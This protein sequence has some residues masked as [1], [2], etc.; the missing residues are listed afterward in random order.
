MQKKLHVYWSEWPPWQGINVNTIRY[1][2][3]VY[4]Q[5]WTWDITSVY[6]ALQYNRPATVYYVCNSNQTIIQEK[7]L[8]PG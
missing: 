8:S 7:L 6:E 3:S 1:V 5:I 2:L 4:K